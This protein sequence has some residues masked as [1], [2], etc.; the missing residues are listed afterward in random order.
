MRHVLVDNDSSADVLYYEAFKR[1]GMEESK[2]HYIPEVQL[3]YPS[4]WG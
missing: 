1:M 2:L 3:R 4:R